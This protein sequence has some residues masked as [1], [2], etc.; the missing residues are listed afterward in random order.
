MYDDSTEVMFT[1]G[2]LEKEVEYANSCLQPHDT[3]HIHT[4]ISWMKSRIEELEETLK[5]LRSSDG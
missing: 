1:I 2:V 3:G 5:S 4:S